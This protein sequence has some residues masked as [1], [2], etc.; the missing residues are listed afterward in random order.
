MEKPNFAMEKCSNY[1]HQHFIF[2]ILHYIQKFTE[3]N[4]QMKPNHFQISQTFCF[5]YYKV[6]FSSLSSDSNH[7]FF[8]SHCKK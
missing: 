4:Q 1:F 7:Q 6:Y 8:D 5:C 2:L 3:A